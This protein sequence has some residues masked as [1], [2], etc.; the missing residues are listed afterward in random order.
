MKD[1]KKLE[2]LPQIISIG[3]GLIALVI[4]TL[5][6]KVEL[7]P[8]IQVI[9][10]GLVIMIFPHLE[11][12]ADEAS[13]WIL[14]LV[15]AIFIVFAVNLGSVM[16]FYDLFLWRDTLMHGLFGFIASLSIYIFFFKDTN[17]KSPVKYIITFLASMGCG[18]LW[19]IF[20]FSVDQIL[21]M[22]TQRV[23]ESISLGKS[24]V[25]DT[26]I[27]LIITIGGFLIFMLISLVYTY[28]QNNKY[29][30]SDL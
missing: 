13:R 20:E 24:P 3:G 18:S 28:L 1:K 10:S 4:H 8:F 5:N 15:Y 16:G 29:S 6:V 9:L 26:M 25:Y 11:F 17:L 12:I 27:D 14:N 2:Y 21:A 22:D 7:I 23:A 19:E 30:S